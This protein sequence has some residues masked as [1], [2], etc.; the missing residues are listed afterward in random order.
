[1]KYL[2]LF[3][4]GS[5]LGSFLNVVAVR[6]M[7]NESFVSGRSHCDSCNHRLGWLDMI[8]VVSWCLLK[9]KCRYCG[10]PIGAAGLLAEIMGGINVLLIYDQYE[11]IRF[12]LYLCLTMNLLLIA[13]MDIQQMTM[14]DGSLISLLFLSI[15]II[16]T[17][18]KAAADVA[19]SALAVAGPMM[20]IKWLFNGFGDGDVIIFL[21]IGAAFG[22][23]KVLTSA[24]LSLF[25]GSVLGLIYHKKKFPFCPAIYLALLI[26]LAYGE[27]LVDWYLYCFF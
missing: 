12:F 19:I 18:K 24:V 5:C 1:M 2:Y 21:L 23:E 9:G 17:E 11:G 25:F 22:L 27:T 26:T 8:P 13:L 16:C 6:T 4:I 10:K 14:T 20:L 3:V 15:L 7:R